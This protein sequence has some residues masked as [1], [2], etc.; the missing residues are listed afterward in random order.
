VTCIAIQRERRHGLGYALDCS[1]S[2]GGSK[3]CKA[4]EET[5][6]LLIF[7]RYI[8][9]RDCLAARSITS[10]DDNMGIRGLDSDNGLNLFHHQIA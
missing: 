10:V 4:G 8:A 6:L 3:S 9:S 2:I 1:R 7:R 5:N